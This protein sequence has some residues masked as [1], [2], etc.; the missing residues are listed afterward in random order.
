MSALV[1]NLRSIW[2]RFESE[3]G[4]VGSTGGANTRDVFT[5]DPD[6]IEATASI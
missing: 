4:K 1:R 6:P 5:S 3:T 2:D